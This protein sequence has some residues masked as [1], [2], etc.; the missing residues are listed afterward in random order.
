MALVN[1][2][3][4]YSTDMK[5][6][7]KNLLLRNCWSDFE[8]IHSTGQRSASYCHGTVSVVRLYV[9]SCVCA[10]VNSSLKKTSPQKLLT[11]FL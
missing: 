11:G 6:F 9:C 3:F 1:G 8:I 10:S 2:G 4:L 7:F 5:T